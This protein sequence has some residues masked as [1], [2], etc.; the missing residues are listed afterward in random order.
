MTTRFPEE[1][2]VPRVG[3]AKVSDGVEV[4][5]GTNARS[6]IPA[7]INAVAQSVTSMPSGFVKRIVRTTNYLQGP[8]G[9]N[10]RWG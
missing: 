5:E 9:G 7:A 2:I 3:Q 10:L 4:K 1:I 6:D 8:R